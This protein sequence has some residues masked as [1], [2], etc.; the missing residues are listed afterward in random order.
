MNGVEIKFG[1]N[2]LPSS[3]AR[4]VGEMACSTDGGIS[5]PI[6][7]YPRNAPKSAAVG[8]RCA[9][10]VAVLSGTP[11]VISRVGR[12]EGS[13]DAKPTVTILKNKRRLTGRRLCWKLAGVPTRAP[14]VPGAELLVF[15]SV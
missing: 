7:L 12:V 13:A 1:K 8:G 6:G 15:E 11:F 2:V 3:I 14:R 5:S 4:C 9:M 10:A